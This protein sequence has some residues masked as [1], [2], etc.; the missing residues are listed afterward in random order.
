MAQLFD[1]VVRVNVEGIA[2]LSQAIEG[3]G[4][5]VNVILVREQTSPTPTKQFHYAGGKRKKGISGGD[6][7]LE[8]LASENRVF[9]DVEVGNAFVKRGFAYGSAR[10]C[11]YQMAKAGKVRALGQCRYCLAGTT[12]N[13]GA[14]AALPAKV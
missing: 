2:K 13:L 14:S 9:T 11:L 3:N 4:Q 6:L 7:V 12:I 10:P 8:I 5:L 1:C